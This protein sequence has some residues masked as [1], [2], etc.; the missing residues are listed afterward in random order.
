[1]KI[2]SYL[3]LLCF[4]G[5]AIA[6]DTFPVV[7]KSY[8]VSYLQMPS[9]Y[10]WPNK[11]RILEHGTGEWYLIE[12]SQPNTEPSNSSRHEK[13]PNP[14]MAEKTQKRWMNFS[15]LLSATQLD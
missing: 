11:I 12:F 8:E 9:G 14:S 1:M 4:A 3:A 5:T 13:S 15:L 7:G 2:P 10:F 6:S